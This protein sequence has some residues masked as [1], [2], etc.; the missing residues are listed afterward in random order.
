M[1]RVRLTHHLVL[2][3]RI[4][5][6][7]RKELEQ[8]RSE[9]RVTVRATRWLLRKG[10]RYLRIPHREGPS[11]GVPRYGGNQCVGHSSLWGSHDGKNGKF[12]APIIFLPGLTDHHQHLS[13][14]LVMQFLTGATTSCIFTVSPLSCSHFTSYGIT[15]GPNTT[16][17]DVRNPSD[18][19]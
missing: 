18:R 5:T 16:T 15:G 17:S 7:S 14:P 11:S 13:A 10:E 1:S 8:E 12:T 4:V 19:L 2:L 9:V 3:G 6:V